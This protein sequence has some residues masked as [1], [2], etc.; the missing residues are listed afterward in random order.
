MF[1]FSKK[2]NKYN[3]YKAEKW[4]KSSTRGFYTDASF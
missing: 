3:S 1:T 2:K 4:Y